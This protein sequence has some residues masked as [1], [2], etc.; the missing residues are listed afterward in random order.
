MGLP[1]PALRCMGPEPSDFF[2]RGREVQT[3]LTTAV[4]RGARQRLSKKGRNSVPSKSRPSPGH[5]GSC[6]KLHWQY[7][8]AWLLHHSEQCSTGGNGDIF[9][10]PPAPLNLPRY[11]QFFPSL[12]KVFPVAC[13]H[14]PAVPSLQCDSRPWAPGSSLRAAV[15]QQQAPSLT[16]L[17]WPRRQRVTLP[18]KKRDSGSESTRSVP[19]TSFTL[20]LRNNLLLSPHLPFPSNCFWTDGK[21]VGATGVH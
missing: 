6:T 9:V 13:S 8:A 18:V 15:L 3:L 1:H 16:A 17:W 11:F 20:Q 21:L 19:P 10:G 12:Q 14:F 2:P 7:S 4:S 5:G